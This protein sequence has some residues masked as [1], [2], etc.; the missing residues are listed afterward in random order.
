MVSQYYVKAKKQPQPVP[1]VIDGHI[2]KL[3]PYDMRRQW[4]QYKIEAF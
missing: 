4:R 2:E 1:D 3:D